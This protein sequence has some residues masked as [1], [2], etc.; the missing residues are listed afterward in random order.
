MLK[1][2]NLSIITNFGCPY[3]CQFCISNSQSTKN[4][5]T[6]TETTKLNIENL[7]NSGKYTRLSI[8]G[9]GDPLYIHNESSDEIS[10]FYKFIITLTN[11]L[12]IHLSIHTN[13]LK[14]SFKL[15]GLVKNFVVSIHKDDYKEKF[16]NWTKRC[17][18]EYDIR[19]AYVIGYNDNDLEIIDNILNY[20]P[21][22]SRLTLKQLD[23]KQIAE[24]KDFEE[25]M[26]LITNN[27]LIKFLPSGDYNTYYNL[28]DD[29]IYSRFK[30]INFN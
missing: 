14:P 17:N 22:N 11:K 28:K 6:L 30:D 20:L 7:L 24:I 1:D 16:I 15:K 26:K 18:N 21:D 5:Y 3:K 29:K 12:N 13:Y 10:E 23:S 4:V 9:G 19:F 2:S 8:S 27:K 25:I